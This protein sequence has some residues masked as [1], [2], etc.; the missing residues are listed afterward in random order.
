VLPGAAVLLRVAL[1]LGGNAGT[2]IFPTAW[3]VRPTIVALAGAAV[4]VLVF[5]PFSGTWRASAV[6]TALF[7]LFFE[8]YGPIANRLYASG[9]GRTPVVVVAA[10]FLGITA[11]MSIVWGR[12]LRPPFGIVAMTMLIASAAI[13]SAGPLVR[14]AVVRGVAAAP[15]VPDLMEASPRDRRPRPAPPDVYLVIL[16]G[17]ARR[18][19]LRERFN[20]PTAPALEHFRRLGVALPARARSN[21]VQTYLSLASSLNGRYIDSSI[22][23]NTS[24]QDRQP[25]QELI[26]ESAIVRRFRAAGYE[27][28]MVASDAA[29]TSR[30]ALADRCFCV[31][32]AGPTELEYVLLAGT[33]VGD[34][35]DVDYAALRTHWRY[36][37]DQFA[38]LESVSG[39]RP[40]LVFA[41]ILVPHPPFVFDADGSFAPVGDR[42]SMLDGTQ[43]PGTRAEYIEGYARQ[44][45]YALAR[46]EVLFDRLLARPRRPVVVVQSDHGS[47]LDLVHTDIT[48]A[49]WSERLRIFSAFAAPDGVELPPEDITPVNAFSWAY[50]AATGTHWAP[51][52]NRSYISTYQRP[53]DFIEAADEP[54]VAQDSSPRGLTRAAG[55]GT[56]VVR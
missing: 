37:R 43:F 31:L 36:V 22:V 48:A 41:H 9:G 28:L 38:T 15:W 54:I 10:V 5:R 19:V 50:A 8:F 56:S 55:H 39:S 17:L 7:T 21:Y 23:A 34:L 29:M 45:R 2:H 53:Y 14:H 49:G 12:R 6:A 42:F 51:L 32:P 33:P 26:D 24:V 4:L 40:L 44:A 47:A 52:P 13:S 30:H 11:G 3:I 16:D 46:L 27:Y 35:V 18:D 1:T 25:L 20:V